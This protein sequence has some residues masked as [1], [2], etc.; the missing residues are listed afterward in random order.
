M[1]EEYVEQESEEEGTEQDS[2]DILEELPKVMREF[3]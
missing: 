3:D 1:S 2:S